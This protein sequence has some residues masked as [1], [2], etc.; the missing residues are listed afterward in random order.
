MSSGSEGPSTERRGA[1][2]PTR[3]GRSLAETRTSTS[4]SE[5]LPPVL[6]VAA[7]VDVPVARTTLD[8][9]TFDTPIITVSA[10]LLL[11]PTRDGA[12]APS[13][14]QPVEDP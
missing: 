7:T 2:V 3:S 8:P 5:S 14:S 12:D 13:P 4:M 6:L 10:R 9:T 11:T 1:F